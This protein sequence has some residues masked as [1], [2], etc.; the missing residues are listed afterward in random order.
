MWGLDAPWRRLEEKLVL[1]SERNHSKGFQS[2]QTTTKRR[3]HKKRKICAVV[4]LWRIVAFGGRQL[5]RVLVF[6][7]GVSRRCHFSAAGVIFYVFNNSFFCCSPN[8]RNHCAIIQNPLARAT[9]R[10]AIAG[11]FA[12]T[13]AAS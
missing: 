12:Q 13:T 11:R 9:L 6:S 5:R 8:P 10:L 4:N 1:P 7:A 3:G 2:M